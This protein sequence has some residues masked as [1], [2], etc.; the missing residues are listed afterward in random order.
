[1]FYE[2]VGDIYIL[3]YPISY[4]STR[5]G[6]DVEAAAGMESDGATG[7]R[8]IFSESWW[9]H[10]QL[11]DTGKWEDGELL[12][13]WQA[14]RVLSDILWSEGRYF[15][16]VYW[17]FATFLGGGGECRKNGMFWIKKKRKK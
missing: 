13:N 16:A 12:T 7:A 8:D 5:Y 6:K 15:R 14:S 11:C 4:H 3:K 17:L 10:D 1:M 9:I 2:R